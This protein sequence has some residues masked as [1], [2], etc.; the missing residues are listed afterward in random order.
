MPGT[1]HLQAHSGLTDLLRSY[2]SNKQWIAAICAAPLILGEMG[3][4][5]GRRATCFP[6]YEHHL[7]GAKHYPI[8]AITDGHII[9]GRGIGAA[10][11]FSIEIVA[12]L[13]GPEKAAELRE[14]MVVPPIA[15]P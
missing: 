12:N 6:G 11:E 9:T 13:F 14:K 7:Q 10:M 1:K 4:L 5:E 15:H 8:P 2:D 3:L